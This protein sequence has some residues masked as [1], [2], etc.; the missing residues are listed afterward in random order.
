[1]S[2]K[3]RVLVVDDHAVNRRI[4]TEIFSHLGCVVA[5]AQDG[6]DALAAVSVEDFDLICLDRR[7]AGLS[8][9]DVVHCLPY[10]RFV[11]AWSTEDSD[12]P[13]RFNGVL[14]KPVTIAAA[15][16]AMAQAIAWQTALARRAADLSRLQVA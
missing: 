6:L 4:L 9:D 3:F 11:L 12:L 7:M 5:T 2:S 13:A 8:G 15:E 10:D 14:A 1:M 16:A